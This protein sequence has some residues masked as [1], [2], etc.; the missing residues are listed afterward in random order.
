MAGIAEAWRRI[1]HRYNLY[2]T[3]CENCKGI[4]FPPRIICPNCRRKGRMADEKLSGRGKILTF[5]IVYAPPEGY[6]LEI[7]YVLAIVELN[8]GPKLTA[9]IVDAKP[10]NVNIGM[11]VEMAFRKLIEQN[12]HG[13]IHYGYKFRPAK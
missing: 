7:P 5:S 4:Y 9:Q 6:S 2:G 13:L 1:K 11:P 8:E 10:E 12:S 3:K